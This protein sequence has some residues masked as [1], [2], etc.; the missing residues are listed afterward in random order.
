VTK[1]VTESG[2]ALYASGDLPLWQRALTAA[3]VTRCEA[4]AGRVNAYRKD[5]AKQRESADQ[6]PDGLD[7]ESLSAEMAAN[8]RVGL[9]AGECVADPNAVLGGRSREG[10]R[11]FIRGWDWRPAAVI[12]GV[13]VFLTGAWWLNVP[14]ADNV[15]LKNVVGAIARGGRDRMPQFVRGMDDRVPVVEVSSSGI[16]VREN[17]GALGVSQE[18]SRPVT[19]SVSVQGSASARYVDTDTGQVTVTSVYVE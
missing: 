14:S 2:L 12:A 10:I 4:C 18:G 9:A 7:W 19:V 1:H 3:H 15:R 11:A 6:M 13:L 8:I 17:G 16:S 5:R